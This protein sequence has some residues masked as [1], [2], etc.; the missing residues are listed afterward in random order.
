MRNGLTPMMKKAEAFATKAHEGQY[1]KSDGKP[2][3]THPIR[4]ANVLRSNGFSEEVVIAG[5]LHDTVEDTDV[6]LEDI[7][8]EF[9]AEV[10]YIVAGNTEDK[11]KSWYERKKHTV[12]ALKTA[13]LSI[14]ALVV[15]DKL[16][17][18]SSM[19]F[20]LE[21]EGE[22][23]WKFFK[24]GRKE[25]AWYFQSVLASM[26]MPH[27]EI[28]PSDYPELF[29]VYQALVHQVFCPHMDIVHED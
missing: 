8:R 11:E 25:N 28:K 16:D 26:Y 24:Y 5:Y 13:P 18:L 17:N 22:A 7:E 21:R 3:V 4:V 20:A 14:R 12:D 29:L 1:R 2:M 6:T 15:A 27:D 23:F 10:R 9:G 19:A